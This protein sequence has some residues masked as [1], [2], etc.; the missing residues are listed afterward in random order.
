[1]DEVRIQTGFV[2]GIITKIIRKIVAKK[3][4]VDLGITF[5]E[6]ISVKFDGENANV[7]LSVMA[8]LSKD[9]LSKLLKDLV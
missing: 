1:M 2:Q 3:L 4:G 7:R 8:A 9:D 5:N 6:P